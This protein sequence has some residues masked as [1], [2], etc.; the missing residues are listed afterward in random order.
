MALELSGDDFSVGQNSKLENNILIME[1]HSDAMCKFNVEDAGKYKVVF[2]VYVSSQKPIDNLLNVKLGKEEWQKD[3]SVILPVLW[4]DET[5]IYGTDRFGNETVPTQIKVDEFVQNAA[6]F[7]NSLFGEELEFTLEKGDYSLWLNNEMEE[8]KIRSIKLIRE[9]AV[10]DYKRYRSQF[11]EQ[12]L[13]NML[14]YY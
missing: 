6:R 7:D 3:Y 9:E 10:V 13:N 12:T 5:K 1:N 8:I 14:F 4:K 2:D 11:S